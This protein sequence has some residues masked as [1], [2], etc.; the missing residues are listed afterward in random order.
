MILRPP[1][2]TRTDTLFPYTTL[3]R[4]PR[5]ARPAQ[6]IQGDKGKRPVNLPNLLTLLR[7]AAVPVLC[8]AFWLPQQAAAL[9]TFSIFA[10]ASITDWLDGYLARRLNQSSEFGRCLD[11]IADKVLVA[12]ALILLR[13]EEHTSE[14][15]SLM[16]ISYAVFCLKKKKQT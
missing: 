1:R 9:A 2:A 8:V 7:I 11:P 16:R 4:S 12:A 14:L 3:F 5:A 15:Q 10:L 13:S 6:T